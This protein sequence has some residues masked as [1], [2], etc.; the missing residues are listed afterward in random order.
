[1][2]EPVGWVAVVLT[3]VFWVPNIARIVRTRDVTGYSVAAWGLML[4]GLVCY[5]VYFTV[6]GDR[7]GTVANLSGVAGA[8]LTLGLVLRWRGRAAESGPLA[9]DI[10][11]GE[12][13]MTPSEA[14]N[15][16][17]NL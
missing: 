4:A 8:G 15:R 14:P 9:S 6:E 12:T 17:V 3:Q 16:P 7:V 1:M 10:K 5:L 2:I 11:S 13:P